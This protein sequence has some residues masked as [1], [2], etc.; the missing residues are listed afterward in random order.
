MEDVFAT[1]R[2]LS[3]VERVSNFYNIPQPLN[4]NFFLCPRM[5]N[6]GLLLNGARTGLR[7][8]YKDGPAKSTEERVDK[9]EKFLQ[10]ASAQGIC[11]RI[12]G[13]FAAADANLLFPIP[14]FPPPPPDAECALLT[15]LGL[16]T[17]T[18]ITLAI[19][20]EAFERHQA[21]FAQFYEEQPWLR[22]PAR[23]WSGE[24]ERL[25]KMLPKGVP[26]YIKVDF[27]R[28]T[29]AGFALDGVLLRKG[30]FGRDP[31]LLGLE[32]PGVP[33]LQNAAL[34]REEWLP[35]IQLR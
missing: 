27:L 12:Q 2:K 8:A 28:R 16:R 32:S 24:E 10:E 1:L 33:A 9:L 6:K 25:V 22:V 19:N 7:A 11:T 26:Q 13:I 21:L 5:T 15:R 31:V 35:V 14:P 34:P 23:F 29:F 4:L 17:K 30:Y 3:S 18:A 20:T